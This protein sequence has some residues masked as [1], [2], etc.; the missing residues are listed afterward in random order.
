M[1]MRLIICASRHNAVKKGVIW[2]MLEV[3]QVI[4]SQVTLMR[5]QD[6]VQVMGMKMK[7]TLLLLV[8]YSR[9]E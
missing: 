2:K 1:N 9:M 3:T 6:Q 8:Q 7:V 4:M 5:M